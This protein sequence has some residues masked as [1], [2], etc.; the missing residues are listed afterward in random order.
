MKAL[1]FGQNLFQKNMDMTTSSILILAMIGLVAGLLSGF[2][3]VG[4]GMIIVP[5]LVFL[6]GASQMTAQGTSLALLMFPVGILGVINYYKTGNVNFQ[7]VIIMGLAFVLGSYFGSKWALK[8][9]E[10]KVKLVFGIFLL[11][12]SIRMIYNSVKAGL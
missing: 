11:Y 8:I 3:G 2:V 10:Q 5:G 1:T 9:S 4:G 12:M 7:Y 6:L